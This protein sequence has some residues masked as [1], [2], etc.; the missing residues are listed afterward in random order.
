[1][2]V[3]PAE[4]FING[5]KHYTKVFNDS[6]ADTEFIDQDFAISLD[7]QT[8]TSVKDH[9]VTALDGHILNK[10]SLETEPVHLTLRGNNH[11]TLGFYIIK[12]PQLLI[13]LG[14]SWLRRPNPHINWVKREITG[15][16]NECLSSCLLDAMGQ[17]GSPEVVNHTDPD[18]SKVPIDYHDLKEVFSKAKASSLPPH[19]PYDCP[20][21]LLPGTIPPRGRLFP[22][23]LPEGQAMKKIEES[24]QAGIITPSVSP[25]EAGF[26]FVSKTLY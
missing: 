26:F 6:G 7:I 25:A 10:D 16:A 24:L 12:S 9:R 21:N 8:K 23:S 11:E 18:L 5:N 14:N 2:L 17:P 22:L 4:L 3:L 15:W 1:M 19:R 13:I 20:I